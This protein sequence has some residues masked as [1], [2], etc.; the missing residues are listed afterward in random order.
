MGWG[1]NTFPLL[2]VTAGGGYTGLF[3][4]NPAPGAGNLIASTAAISG[5]DPSGNAFFEGTAAYWNTSLGLYMA[6][7]M[8]PANRGLTFYTATTEAGPWTARSGLFQPVA[9]GPVLEALLLQNV[10]GT[11][12]EFNG[13]GS[14]GY[15]FDSPGTVICA[16]GLSVASGTTTDTLDVT[17]TAFLAEQVSAPATPSGG[18]LLYVDST[19]H[20]H[21][22]GPG[23]TNTILANP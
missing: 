3:V 9:G 8:S 23:G 15:R 16:D 18:G 10:A 12:I 1:G 21:Y 6:L 13:G 5:T 4:Y 20:L 2:V 14:F 19:G 17:T 11:G 7:V 22:L